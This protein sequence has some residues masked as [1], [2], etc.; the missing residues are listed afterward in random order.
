MSQPFGYTDDDFVDARDMTALERV[1]FDFGN[2][3]QEGIQSELSKNN[4]FGNKQI[5]SGELYQSVNFSTEIFGSLF[6]FR[7]KL[8]DYYDYVNK[9]VRGY[10]K[11]KNK[12]FTSPYRFGVKQPPIDSLKLWSRKRKLNPFA[13]ARSI[14]DKGIEGSGFYDKVVT[15][16][17]LKQLQ[18][19]LSNASKEDVRVIVQA[20]AKGVFGKTI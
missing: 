16:E 13:V 9:G 1:L 17:R 11:K 8:S 12:N 19:D 3:M 2:E 18:R 5:D 14:R 20:T 4:K 6:N 15:P 7:L 10:D